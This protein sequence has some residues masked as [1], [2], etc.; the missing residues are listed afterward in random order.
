VP[1]AES[2]V[3]ATVRDVEPPLVRDESPLAQDAPAPIVPAA[4]ASRAA[5]ARDAVGTITVLECW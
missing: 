1:P 5:K 2:S 3:F 4:I